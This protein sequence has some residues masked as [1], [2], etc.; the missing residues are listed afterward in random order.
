MN[1]LTIGIIFV[2]GYSG[3][4]Q[5]SDL[6]TSPRDIG[7][8]TGLSAGTLVDPSRDTPLVLGGMPIGLR[9]TEN[10]SH[11]LSYVYQGGILLDLVN[12]QIV[13]QN[14]EAGISYHLLG[15]S[16]QIERQTS[17]GSFKGLSPSNL[18]LALRASYSQF[19]ASSANDPKD[20]VSGSILEIKT[21]SS[22]RMDIFWESAL[23]FE[24]MLVLMGFPASVDRIQ[25][26]GIELNIVW[27][28]Y[29]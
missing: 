16:R 20:K 26:S 17:M 10:S 24:F 27:R 6:Q 11:S 19:S 7:F 29:L 3:I 18:S 8:V 2:L 1:V 5:G 25:H 23:E 14:I 22:Y 28:R 15:G 4:S 12:T 9:L 13:R 21:G